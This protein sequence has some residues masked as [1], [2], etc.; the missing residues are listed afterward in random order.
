MLSDLKV[1]HVAAEPAHGRRAETAGARIL[2]M[3]S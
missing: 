1:L 2:V 3:H